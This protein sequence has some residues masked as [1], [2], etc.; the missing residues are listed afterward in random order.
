MH[1]SPIDIPRWAVL[2]AMATALA[3]T[4]C[5]REDRPVGGSQN[6]VPADRTNVGGAD[7]SGDGPTALGPD[8][9]PSAIRPAQETA[10]TVYSSGTTGTSQM[11]TAVTPRPSQGSPNSR[12]P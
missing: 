9:R 8:D 1:T 4:A 2:A 5:G 3:M 6:R 12:G 7:G 10:S 11:P